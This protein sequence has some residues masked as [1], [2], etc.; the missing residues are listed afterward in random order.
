M[1]LTNHRQP[2]APPGLPLE[3]EDFFKTIA[4]EYLLEGHQV[5]LLE[6]AAQQLAR[7]IQARLVLNCDGLTVLNQRGELKE[8][9]C[10]TIERN[11]TGMFLR[12]CRELGFDI[13]AS[14]LRGPSR[15]GTRRS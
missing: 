3:A 13:P 12:A 1:T 7:A 5:R 2:Q 6:L 4:A 10:V 9:P 15:P 11:A 8:H 14:S